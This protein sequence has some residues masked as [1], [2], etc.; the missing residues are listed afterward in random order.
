MTCKDITIFTL[1]TLLSACSASA[2]TGHQTR[3]ASKP[4]EAA[5]Q[6][7]AIPGQIG[8]EGKTGMAMSPSSQPNEREAAMLRK[9]Y[10]TCIKASGGV[11]PDMQDCIDDEYEHQEGR[12]RKA[13]EALLTR[14]SAD[15]KADLHAEQTKWLSERDAQCD[16]DEMQGGQAQRLE[17]NSCFLEMTAKR[18]A[19]LEAR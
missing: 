19:E 13:F 3:S 18:A 17:A 8:D 5:V 16:W 1:A 9:S 6:R 4:M 14:P 10:D 15:T 7:G 11:T 12:L 2:P